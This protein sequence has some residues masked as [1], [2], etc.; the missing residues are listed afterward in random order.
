M[1]MSPISTPN[2]PKPV[3][4]EQPAPQ[5]L[6]SAKVTTTITLTPD[7]IKQLDE[8][9]REIATLFSP[10]GG[11]SGELDPPSMG[12]VRATLEENKAL[13]EKLSSLQVRTE[14][15]EAFCLMFD[16]LSAAIGKMDAASASAQEEY[17]YTMEMGRAMFEIVSSDGSIA[18]KQARIGAALASNPTL[19]AEV[20][21]LSENDLTALILQCMKMMMD[22]NREMQKTFQEMGIAEAQMQMS[23]LSDAARH[24]R[25]AAAKQMIATVIQGATQVAGGAMQAGSAARSF[26]NTMKG[27]ELGQ[28][29]NTIDQ[30]LKHRPADPNSLDTRFDRMQGLQNRAAHFNAMGAKQ[31]SYGQ[32]WGQATGGMGTTASA[33]FTYQSQMHQADADLSRKSATA[34]EISRQTH[35]AIASEGN[36][37]INKGI[38]LLQ[39]LLSSQVQTSKHIGSRIAG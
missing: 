10:A 11:L 18:Q 35:W 29:A 14:D 39:S 22:S 8:A 5:A 17:D 27:H 16:G 21:A 25:S 34:A 36:S 15:A 33:G 26:N 37:G 24:T 2:L 9:T 28:K 1:S 23:M 3:Q 13:H 20:M 32:A 30:D 12:T 4:S 6:V 7:Q 19:G 31:H 38:D